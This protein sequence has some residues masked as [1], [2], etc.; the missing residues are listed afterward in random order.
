MTRLK[1]SLMIGSLQIQWSIGD[2]EA[3]IRKVQSQIAA[4]NS[5]LHLLLLRLF[6]LVILSSGRRRLVV[7]R[8]TLLLRCPCVDELD[9][10]ERKSDYEFNL[11]LHTRTDPW[12]ALIINMMSVP[13]RLRTAG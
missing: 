6:S 12:T 3:Y 1:T 10:F 4:L 2:R 9:D 8:S 13:S 7:G 5:L 11:N